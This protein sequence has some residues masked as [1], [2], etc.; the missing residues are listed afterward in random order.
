MAYVGLLSFIVDA[1][2][3]SMYFPFPLR[4][5]KLT[6]LYV[7]IDKTRQPRP[8]GAPNCPV[9]IGDARRTEKNTQNRICK[10]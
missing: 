10:L 2:L 9:V 5:A 6:A 7:S 3:Y 1:I 8:L 4:K